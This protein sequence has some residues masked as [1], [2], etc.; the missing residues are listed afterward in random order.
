MWE[1]KARERWLRQR[2]V[3]KEEKEQELFE[4]KEGKTERREI[5]G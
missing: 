1:E 3:E 5:K 2:W 4:G